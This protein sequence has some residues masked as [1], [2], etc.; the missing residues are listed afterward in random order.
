MC[1]LALLAIAW[2]APLAALAGARLAAVLPGRVDTTA[3]ATTVRAPAFRPPA[4]SPAASALGVAVAIGGASA[5]LATLRTRPRARATTAGGGTGGTL[6]FRSAGAAARLRRGRPLAA[7]LVSRGRAAGRPTVAR[8]RIAASAPGG[9]VRVRLQHEDAEQADTDGDPR[10]ERHRGEAVDQW[11]ADRQQLVT[12]AAYGGTRRG[13]H[14]CRYRDPEDQRRL[15]HRPEHPVPTH[16]RDRADTTDEVRRVED[17]AEFAG[18][19]I[20]HDGADDRQSEGKKHDPPPRP[21]FR[22]VE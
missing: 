8:A 11:R 9:G 5:W 20:V 3:C 13:Q 21:A 19:L 17:R 10:G 12:Q 18:Q 16:H 6:P 4:P 14:G 1:G 15:H 2:P 7:A 22:A